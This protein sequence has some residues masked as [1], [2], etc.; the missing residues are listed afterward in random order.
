MYHQKK[1]AVRCELVHPQTL[2][3]KSNELFR[4]QPKERTEELPDVVYR[5]QL[6][7]SKE[8]PDTH[9][10]QQYIKKPD[11]TYK[12][13]NVI[14]I[15][16]FETCN[17]ALS[18]AI[19]QDTVTENQVVEKA[20][21]APAPLVP[22]TPPEQQNDFAIYQLKGGDEAREIRFEAFDSLAKQGVV[23]DIAN[24]DLVYEG[25]ISEVT[26]SP[27]LRLQLEEL[28]HTFN[29]EH[30]E[31]FTGHSLSVSDV[32]VVKDQAFYVDMFGFRP[33][34]DFIKPELTENRTHDVVQKQQ[35][36]MGR[37]KD[38]STETPDKQK[39][40]KKPKL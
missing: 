30:P 14:A 3:E 12:V 25:R 7:A 6:N 24:Y 32:V 21:A 23:P 18:V 16:D 2:D 4:Q 27:D 9:Y 31:D 11:D 34:P 10:V 26:N 8:S 33:L 40:P 1:D 38:A 28:F 13:G 17:A 36:A 37:R 15:G 22:P 29:M 5:I 39:Q 19:A 20:V 35:E